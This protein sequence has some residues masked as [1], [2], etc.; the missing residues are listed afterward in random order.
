MG[1]WSERQPAITPNAIWCNGST[2]GKPKLHITTLTMAFAVSIDNLEL[3]TTTSSCTDN[4]IIDHSSKSKDSNIDIDATSDGN[5]EV[6]F[7][8]VTMPSINF[9]PNEYPLLHSLGLQKEFQ[10]HALLWE[11]VKYNGSTIEFTQKK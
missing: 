7:S 2:Y 3:T 10:F 1:S 6:E 9:D 11:I 8:T 5:K 4:T